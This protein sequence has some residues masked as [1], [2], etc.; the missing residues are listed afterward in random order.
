MESNSP[1][2]LDARGDQGALE[3]KSPRNQGLLHC[4]VDYML[5]WLEGVQNSKISKDYIITT[6]PH[7]YVTNID[8]VGILFPVHPDLP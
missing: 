6:S 7:H 8:F 5:F 2:V 1:G 3:I 4:D